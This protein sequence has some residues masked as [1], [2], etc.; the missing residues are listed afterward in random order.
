MRSAT[1]S[2]VILL[3]SCLV[4]GAP[5]SAQRNS[6]PVARSTPGATQVISPA[7]VATWFTEGDSDRGDFLQLVVLWRGSP[8][9]FDAPGGMRGSSNATESQV[10]VT[11]GTVKLRV[12]FNSSQ[13]SVAINDTHVDTGNANV[14]FVDNVDGPTGPQVVGTAQVMSA[15]PGSARQIGVVLRTSRAA[16]TFLKCDATSSE[17]SK[18]RAIEHN[19][20]VKNLGVAR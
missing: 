20:C 12:S 1:G 5:A 4:A 13:H 18:Q 19:S 16:M 7:V 15:M 3:A 9:W 10:S 6:P 14:I 8:G 11:Y 17:P 2:A